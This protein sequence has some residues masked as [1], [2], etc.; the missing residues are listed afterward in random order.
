M[1]T[2]L[3]LVFICSLCVGMFQLYSQIL[4]KELHILV[5]NNTINTAVLITITKAS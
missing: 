1:P 4:D 5:L 2:T 3:A